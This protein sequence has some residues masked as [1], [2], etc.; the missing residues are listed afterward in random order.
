M[1]GRN[2]LGV[3]ERHSILPDGLE[4]ESG[5]HCGDLGG[6]GLFGRMTEQSP[7]TQEEN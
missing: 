6:G 3:R 7:L 1:S 2:L 5:I 4:T